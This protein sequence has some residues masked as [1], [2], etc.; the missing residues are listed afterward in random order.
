MARLGVDLYMLEQTQRELG[1]QSNRVHNIIPE[2]Y[3]SIGTWN[4][5]PCEAV[6]DVACVGFYLE[7]ARGA[8]VLYLTDSAYSPRTFPGLTHMMVECSYDPA[9]V[10]ER[11][12]D[13][14]LHP[15]VKRRL[16][17]THMS[18]DTL[19]E[20]LRAN[21]LSQLQEIRLLHLSGDNSNADEFVRRVREITGRPVYVAE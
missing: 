2:Q 14:S 12:E 5:Y 1:L 10:A 9:V 19:C 3:F 13:G 4:I 11:T 21:D 8:R 18:I 17:Q 20:M 7:S 16:L 15:A 6:H